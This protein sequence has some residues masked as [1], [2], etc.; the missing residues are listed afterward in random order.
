MKMNKLVKGLLVGFIALQMVGC[1]EA[2]EVEN[3][4]VQDTK[5]VEENIGNLGG[6][7][8]KFC[9]YC[10]NGIFNEKFGEEEYNELIQATYDKLAKLDMNKE[11]EREKYFYGKRNLECQIKYNGCTDCAMVEDF[12][13]ECHNVG[14]KMKGEWVD[15]HL[16]ICKATHTNVE[17]LPT[18]EPK[19]EEKVEAPVV[20]EE[21]VV[22][23]KADEYCYYC[24]TNSHNGDKCPV[25]YN[26]V[27]CGKTHGLAESYYNEDGMSAC[28][29]AC[30]NA[31]MDVQL[32]GVNNAKCENCGHDVSDVIDNAGGYWCEACDYVK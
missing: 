9:E 25:K 15:E 26:C 11:D 32:E 31:Y 27:Y 23:A 4:E 1:E 16:E 18:E 7:Y 22:S 6:E 21:P 2:K 19:V 10:G 17:N 20:K 14:F 13:L 30:F 12:L 5:P 3:I 29:E 24:D 8:Y 28:S